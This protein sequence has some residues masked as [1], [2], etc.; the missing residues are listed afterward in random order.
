MTEILCLNV[1]QNLAQA[2]LVGADT[3]FLRMRPLG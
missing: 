2:A 1:V 3:A